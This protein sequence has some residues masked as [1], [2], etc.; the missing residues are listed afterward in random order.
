[1]ARKLRVNPNTMNKWWNTAIKK[2]IIIPPIFRRKSFLNFREY[3]CFLEVEDPHKLLELF[4]RKNH[5]L[6]YFSVQTG[7]CNFQ[8]VSKISIK[9]QGKVV[10]LGERSDYF[11]SRPPRGSFGE[12]IRRINLSLKNLDALEFRESPLKFYNRSY[13]PWDEKDEEIFWKI[14]NDM[15]MPFARIVQSTET[16]NNKAWS[17]FRRREEFG[18]EIMFFFPEGESAYVP[19][20]YVID[21]DCD[22]IL[23]DIFSELPTTTV[24]YRLANKVIMLAYL[25]FTLEGRSIVRKVL[26]ILQE[27]EL[28]K[29]YTN[30]IIEYHFRT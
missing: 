27:R 28:V 9:P 30:S 12:S 4:R 3:F 17:W 22:S 6:S 10:L 5:G 18:S 1:M 19:S 25:P 29:G 7:F 15:R 11:V 20:L 24:F 8:M 2:R 16:Y 23:I 21:T 14:C 13:E 26:S